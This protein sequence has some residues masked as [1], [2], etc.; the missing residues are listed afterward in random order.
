MKSRDFGPATATV[1]DADGKARVRRVR[2]GLSSDTEVEIVEG[3]SDT[4]RLVEGP[5]RVLSKELKDGDA[6]VPPKGKG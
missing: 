4:D 1:V 3:L 6:V 5:Y 2:T